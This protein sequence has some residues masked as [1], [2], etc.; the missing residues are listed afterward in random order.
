MEL[1]R[2]RML[3]CPLC[4]YP[5]HFSCAIPH[6][7]LDGKY[8]LTFRGAL[9]GEDCW[10]TVRSLAGQAVEPSECSEHQVARSLDLHCTR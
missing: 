7:T 5:L 10:E 2:T 8:I 1:P 9:H 6:P 3:L 4:V